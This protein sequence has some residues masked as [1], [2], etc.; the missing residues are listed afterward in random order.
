MFNNTTAEYVLAEVID[1]VDVGSSGGVTWKWAFSATRCK[2]S[3]Y[4]DV[5]QRGNNLN[6]PNRKIICRTNYVEKKENHK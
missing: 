4:K 1:K 5:W 2:Y 6:A 3:T